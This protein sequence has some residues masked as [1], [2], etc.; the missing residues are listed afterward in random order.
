[1]AAP[2]RASAG[3]KIKSDEYNANLDYYD[4]IIP[5]WSLVPGTPTRVSNTQF[6]ITDTGNANSYDS[7]FSRGVVLKWTNS[8]TKQAVVVSSSYGANVVTINI[9]GDILAAGF[10]VM[11]YAKEKARVISF[12]SPGT[13]AVLADIAGHFNVPFPIKIFGADGYHGT[14][15]TTNAS[16][17]DINKNGTT[18]M[19]AKLSIASAATKGEGYT[20]DTATTATTGDYISVDCDSISTTPPVDAY[21]NVLYAPLNNIYLP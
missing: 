16:T 20:A 6:T 14:A 7:L 8:G 12:A 5:F 4:G 1:M 19:T 10:T 17:Y 18:F 3:N 13:M 15:G 9:M 21:I 2:Y 11:S